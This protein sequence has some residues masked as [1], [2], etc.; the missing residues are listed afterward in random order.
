[1]NIFDSNGQ[2]RLEYRS[3]PLSRKLVDQLRIQNL[4]ARSMEF[5]SKLDTRN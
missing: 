3:M 5:T 2:N 4:D 1:M